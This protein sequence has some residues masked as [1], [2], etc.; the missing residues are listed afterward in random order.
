MQSIALAEKIRAKRLLPPVAA[1]QPLREAAGVSRQDL[2][3][4]ISRLLSEAAGV[5]RRCTAQA[6]LYWERGER[7]PRGA[8]LVAYSRVLDSLRQA[9]AS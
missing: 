8:Y 6:V 2:A 7:E 4:E 3:D 9:E 1:R 5:D